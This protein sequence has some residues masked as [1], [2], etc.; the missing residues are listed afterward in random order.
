MIVAYLNDGD[1]F[2]EMGLFDEKD[3]RSAWVRAKTECEIGEISYAKFMEISAIHPEFLFALGLQMA[4]RLRASASIRLRRL[5]WCFDPRCMHAEIYWARCIHA[6]WNVHFC[7]RLR[8]GGAP[9]RAV[10]TNVH[11]KLSHWLM[12]LPKCSPL[13]WAINTRAR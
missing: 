10:R 13:R 7:L 8:C 4:R 5:R 2:G 6:L 1:F 11:W 12:A 3:N 9:L